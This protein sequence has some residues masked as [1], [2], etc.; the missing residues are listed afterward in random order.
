MDNRT[1]SEIEAAAWLL[2]CLLIDSAKPVDRQY[3]RRGIEEAA[4]VWSVDVED[5]WWK[6]IVEAGLSLGLKCKVIDGTFDQVK[7]MMV[8]GARILFRDSESEGWLA[9]TQTRGRQGL[10]F[11]SRN[12]RKKSWKS[13]R[14]I[15]QLLPRNEEGNIVRCVVFEP[16][17]TSTVASG[18]ESPERTPLSRLFSLL[19]PESA[20]I[21]VILIFA[22]VTGLLALATPLAVET[23]VNTVAFGSVLQ[24]VI[25]LALMLFGFL[26]FSAA[27]RGLQAVVVEMIQR[28]LFARV[29]A[30]LS[31]RLPRVEWDSLD[32]AS[33][34]ELVNRFFDV[35]TVQKVSAQLLLDGISLVLGTLIGMAVLA[36]Y[37]PWLL[38]FDVVLL[39]LIAFVVFVLGRGA[40]NTSIKESKTKYKMAAWLE[41]LVNCPVAFRQG[42]A[43]EFALDR[44][45]HHIHNYLSARRNHFRILMRQIIFA[46]ALQA[47]A[48]TVLLG[49][50]GWLVMSGQLTLGQ[51]VAAELI[52][53]VI[54][55]SFAKLG[56]HVESY[57]DLIASVDK[58]GVLF[59]L[60]VEPQDG[61][62][63]F[64]SGQPARVNIHALSYK[65]NCSQQAVSDL[66]FIIEQGDRIIID[67]HHGSGASLLLDILFG[68]RKPDSGFLSINEVDPRDLRPDAL[69]R[70]VALVRDV[71]IF[72]GT[73]AENI[74]LERPN[75]STPDIREALSQIGLLDEIL[76]L[77]N[78]LDTQIVET[79]Y[80]LTPTQTKKIMIARAIVNR[81]TLLLV[82]RLLDGLPDDDVRQI[83]SVLFSTEQPWTLVMVTGRRF[84]M[85]GPVKLL[86]LARSHEQRLIEV[87]DDES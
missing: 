64:T 27:L 70:Y 43:A 58:L 25:I 60:P 74:H 35:V 82:D 37:H 80:P 23:L 4:S 85:D 11:D 38:G 59:D 33:G 84:L 2:E 1:R 3:I 83:A 57:Y 49:L 42:G 28:R 32:G 65:G 46:L 55:G 30:D 56:K 81:P 40:I 87:D 47:I 78:G 20:D 71:E 18:A 61:L 52:V 76:D 31:Y 54:V 63:A 67:D 68:M 10:V 73:I 15:K 16:Q 9:I 14:Q 69:R 48:S 13:F 7:E 34:R 26:S 77:P 51:L 66:N 22:L 36:F 45:D 41:S 19:A 50:G 39:A 29:A 12:D 79:G 72:D 86:N 53:T 21:V 17:L 5:F 6:W 24:P 8:D 62:L 75:V 44:T